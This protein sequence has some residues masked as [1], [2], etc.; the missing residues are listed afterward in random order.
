VRAAS[1]SLLTLLAFAW[2]APSACQSTCS[3]HLDCASDEYC[4]S[5]ACTGLGSLLRKPCS[6]VDECGEGFC[7]SGWCYYPGDPPCDCNPLDPCTAIT[8]A[9]A[10]ACLAD[11][12]CADANACTEDRCVDT[13]C[14]NSPVETLG[15]CTTDA[16]CDDQDV[17][18]LDAC[19]A[20]QC[21]HQ[22]D[23]ASGC[24]TVAADCDDLDPCTQDACGEDG[25]CSNS[26][27][28]EGCCTLDPQCDDGQPCT[29]D[30]CLAYR[31]VHAR[32]VAGESCSCGTAADCDDSNPCSLQACVNGTCAYEQDPAGVYPDSKCCAVNGH[33]DDS[34]PATEDA[35]RSFVCEHATKV[36]CEGEA[37]CIGLDPC[38]LYTCVQ[39]ACV[40]S[41]H[42][43]GCCVD[44]AQCDDGDACTSDDC[45]DNNCQHDFVKN[46]GCCQKDTHCDDG[47]ACTQDFCCLDAF[48]DVSGQHVA[49]NHCAFKAAGAN[50]CI[51]DA[52]CKDENWCT[53]DK[54][55]DHQCVHTAKT[56]CCYFE[57][58]CD[59]D[60]W[61]SE[62]H[63]DEGSC[64]HAFSPGC[65]MVESECDD[66]D[67]CTDDY[68]IDHGCT[69]K[70][71][72]PCCSSDL[73]CPSADPCKAG[74]CVG[75]ACV[76]EVKPNCCTSSEGCNDGDPCT[77]DSCVS[78]QCVHTSDPNPFCCV[79]TL[80]QAA[81]FDGGDGV[82]WDFQN[83]STQVG[84]EVS[85]GSPAASG[86]GALR[87]HNPA[88]HD[89]VTPG[90][91]NNGVAVSSP[92]AVPMQDKVL[93]GFKVYGDVRPG[94]GQDTLSLEVHDGTQYIKV[95]DK[96]DLVSGL[97]TSFQQVWISSDVFAG[98]NVRLRFRFDTVDAPASTGKGVVIDDV[99][100]GYGCKYGSTTCGMDSDCVDDSPC[101]QDTC[102]DG[103]CQYADLTGP[104]CCGTP[105][106][107]SSF[108][109]LP[110]GVALAA[111]YPATQGAVGWNLTQHRSYSPP[112]SL[113]FGHPT[114]FTYDAPGSATGGT[115]TLGGLSL[116]GMNAP[117]LA[118]KLWLAIEKIAFVD[119]FTITVNG[120][121][122]WSKSTLT[123]AGYQVD[124][125]SGWIPVTLS[126]SAWVGQTV[127]VVVRFDTLD[128]SG[129]TYEGIYLDDLVVGEACGL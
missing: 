63:C 64:S 82:T 60:V 96:G 101:T 5:G 93:I 6:N 13:K 94:L 66:D 15:C 110:S 106:L 23:P 69:H 57:E 31:C 32:T 48:C 115:V 118:F 16:A 29:D 104:G 74:L 53:D 87:Y 86:Q 111:L 38:I 129:N 71:K 117:V 107:A 21:T 28:V 121:Q 126:L 26:A 84:W 76:Y 34:N 61:C 49:T 116:A 80:V 55:V 58:D 27:P 37:D 67:P 56:E 35:C 72:S 25:Q 91:P 114:Q 42:S 44:D 3:S 47:V 51:Q 89:Y 30:L 70:P 128:D 83:S 124:G 88:A 81:Y 99:V 112:N 12:E 119:Q 79:P 125:S 18:T 33:C 108:N 59:D 22:P 45:Q 10:G 100:V 95:W 122:V 46:P 103:K 9:C 8:A 127:E 36:T 2:I 120:Q 50:C 1:V 7:I 68:C 78:A 73:E 102:A 52:E 109:G 123:G 62:D 105:V 85:Q 75:Q 77:K 54:C 14:V 43:A 65:C 19:S 40:E 97:T 4:K 113:Y 39:G 11:S 98:K 20:N 41:Q 17:C 92:V 24:C 90:A